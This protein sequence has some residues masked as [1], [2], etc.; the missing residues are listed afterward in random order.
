[1]SAAQSAGES[2][3]FKTYGDKMIDQYFISEMGENVF[4]LVLLNID[5]N[6]CLNHT[7]Q[8]LPFE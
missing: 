4:E 7:Y 6:M 1:M 5:T 8:W 3:M 2:M